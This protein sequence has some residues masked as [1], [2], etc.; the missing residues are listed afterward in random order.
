MNPIRLGAVGYLNARPLV[1]GLETGPGPLAGA[2]AGGGAPAVT[3]RFDVPSVCAKLLATGDID[4]GLIPTIAYVDRPGDV[5][6][7]DV[8]IASEGA[9]AS[10]A[11]FTRKPAR[12]IRTIALDTS[13]RTSVALTRVLAAR[14]FEIAP[15]FVPQA[16]DLATMLSTCDAALLIGDP[17]LFVDYRALGA[18]KIDLGETWTDLTG[19]PFVWAFW[20]GRA[21]IVDAA[22]VDRL[23]R[24]RDAGVADSDA[25]AD[26]YCAGEAA[27]QAVA[28]SYLRENI[29]YGLPE[30]AREG[31][32]RFYAEA[33]A[34]GLVP[35]EQAPAFF[36]EA[37][38]ARIGV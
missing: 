29:Q 1:H 12:D 7:P 10:V 36:G 6:V 24:A 5:I 34:L 21:D 30:R 14:R 4:L 27:R 8:A 17:A 20:A 3:I 32:L 9:V 37:N 19:L 13:S 26:A 35:A 22:I 2:G 31:L 38:Q 15:A 11:L 16:P 28:R 25:I 18:D 33:A 23:Q